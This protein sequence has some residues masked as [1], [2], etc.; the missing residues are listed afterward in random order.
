ML[1]LAI[2]FSGISGSVFASS[3]EN[4]PPSSETADTTSSEERDP[5]DPDPNDPDNPIILPDS[6][7]IENG[8]AKP[9]GPFPPEKDEC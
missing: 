8:D 4:T 6:D 5:K 2:S 7:S 3:P 9:H 1:V